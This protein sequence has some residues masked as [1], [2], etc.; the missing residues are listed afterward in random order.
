M[1]LVAEAEPKQIL[2]P[3]WWMNKGQFLE[4]FLDS[5]RRGGEREIFPG[6]RTADGSFTL[7]HPGYR[8]HFHSLAGAVS[9]AERKFV[10]PARLAERL[11][12]GPVR[13][14]E[15]GFGLGINTAA[16]LRCAETADNPLEI[17]SLELDS[18][19]L[20]AAEAL[21][22]EHSLERELIASLKRTGE[23]RCGRSSV[24]LLS[25][26][27]RKRIADAIEYHFGLREQ[28]P[29]PFGL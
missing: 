3:H 17:V 8:Q 16:A 2:A 12:D 15:I 10:E 1:R 28:P 7:Y 29:A 26:D 22:P 18:R 23:Y 5:F 24:R 25:G 9:E 14:L 6:I 19:V 11:A 21:H 20:D 13:L 4:F 27:A